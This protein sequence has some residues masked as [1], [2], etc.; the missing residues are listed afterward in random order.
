MTQWGVLKK[1]N[2]LNHH[3]AEAAVISCRTSWPLVMARNWAKRYS[4]ASS[5]VILPELLILTNRNIERGHLILTWDPCPF[6]WCFIQVLFLWKG[7]LE[8][9]GDWRISE[10][11]TFY[12]TF[13]SLAPRVWW[14]LSKW[15]NYSWVTIASISTPFTCIPVRNS[16]NLIDMLRW[17]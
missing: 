1:L 3:E 8:S 17:A 5:I 13:L 6:S 4:E 9:L 7:V 12:A 2:D 10:G 14:E 15:Y 16:N 11:K